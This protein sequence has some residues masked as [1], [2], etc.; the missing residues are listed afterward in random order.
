[1][2]HNVRLMEEDLKHLS[3]FM[4]GSST[5]DQVGLHGAYSY[6]KLGYVIDEYK[7]ERERDR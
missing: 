6:G 2:M 1:M 7:F 4:K 3:R 5:T